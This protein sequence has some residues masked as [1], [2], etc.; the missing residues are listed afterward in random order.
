MRR[1]SLVLA[2]AGFV[3]AA[4]LAPLA[5]AEAQVTWTMT[6]E[7]TMKFARFMQEVGGIKTAPRSWQ[8]LFIAEIHGLPGS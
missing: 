4:A 3:L 7:Q 2:L 5:H 8:D 6:P 1:S